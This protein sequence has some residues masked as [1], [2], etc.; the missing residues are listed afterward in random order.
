MF[1][2]SIPLWVWVWR[3][4]PNYD[5]TMPCVGHG[6]IRSGNQCDSDAYEWLKDLGNI[7]PV[8]HMQQTDGKGS[9]HWPF[10]EEY[11]KLGMIIPEKVFKTIEDSGA[12][13]TIIVFEFFYSAHAIP[14]EGALDNLK[15]SI[16]YWKKALE[17]A[18]G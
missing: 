2:I 9:R 3:I 16:E 17:K 13:K 8:I 6:Y 10:T 15:V 4:S 12:K 7:S 11:N 5:V 18:Y 14:D 1:A